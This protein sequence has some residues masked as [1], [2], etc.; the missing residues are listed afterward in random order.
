MLRK[1]ILSIAV[2]FAGTVSGIFAQNNDSGSFSI[3]DQRDRPSYNTWEVYT[4][5]RISRQIEDLSAFESGLIAVLTTG[6]FY[7]TENDLQ[8]DRLRLFGTAQGKHDIEATAMA[9]DVNGDKLWFSYANG[10]ISSF[11]LR[12]GQFRHF[13]DIARND[14]FL[15]NRINAMTY[16]DGKLYIGTD[17]GAV[18]FNTTQNFVIDS[19]TTL[20]TFA[21]MIPVRSVA[22]QNGRIY[23]GTDSGLAVGDETSSDLKI[24][25]NWVNYSQSNGFVSQAVSAIAA[26]GS[27]IYATSGNTNYVFDGNG[28]TT[29]SLF[30]GPVRRYR[31]ISA[32]KWS[33]VTASAAYE[34]DT[35]SNTVQVEM[36][37]E[38]GRTLNDFL[39]LGSLQ[40]APTQENG[41]AVRMG[42]V[43]EFDY[44]I[45]N[46][47][48]H[49]FFT[50]FHVAENG[51]LIGSTSP[52]PGRFNSGVF[53]T[54]FY[55][56]NEGNWQN[57]NSVTNDTMSLYGLS[58]YYTAAAAK[59]HYFFGSWGAGIAKY[60]VATGKVTRFNPGNAN[61]FG[62]SGTSNFYVAQGLAADRRNEDHVWAVSLG[63]PVNPLARYSIS[64][65][66]WESY[67]AIPQIG[68]ALRY[69][70]IYTD[71]YG[72]KWITLSNSALAGRGILVLRNPE[73]GSGEFFILNTNEDSGNL[74]N[75]QV[76][77]IVQD[78]RGEIWVGTDRG[79]SRF[80]FP[81]RIIGGSAMERRGQPLINEDTTAFDRV[82]LRDVRV[83]AL[84][85]D[86]NN[87]KWVGSDGDG[88]YLIEE[89]GRRVI[90]HFTRENSPLTSNTIESIAINTQTG[91]VFIATPN[92]LAKYSALEKEGLSRMNTLRIY[93]N[94]F[95]YQRD[96][97]SRVVIEDLLDNSTVHIMTVDGRLVRRFT[98]R[99]G[100]TDWDGLDSN[101]NRV[102]SG[103][104]LIVAT[105]N[106]NSEIGRG[107][108]VIV[109]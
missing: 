5:H 77:A 38:S 43:Q 108:L 85:V 15:S 76:N 95:S 3:F 17:F 40:I 42:S 26:S 11:D 12:T 6:G 67:N 22:V 102:S 87:Q 82:L 93:P 100:R 8:T 91:D 36:L 31:Q 30:N 50:K 81:D 88:I 71:T 78:R 79:I 98:T 7:I 69:Y 89:S 1:T 28:W 59:G 16:A 24:P 94:P 62:L 97:D 103:V 92:S 45:P 46:G 13:N 54:G 32:S 29:T 106:N 35:Q 47:P 55:I 34:L 25:G 105:G 101:G 52:A 61:I 10:M 65:G 64:T 4:S 9:Y 63:N 21:S 75:D 49:N 44:F 107:R 58:S 66:Q 90:R 2:I 84:A 104:Y 80:I 83:T 48:W 56:Y 33:V 14:R 51:D 86:A 18:V 19:Y 39:K 41:L 53:N 74:P 68:T 20:G 99:G 109:R 37:A 96:A 73:G 72:Q 23:A 57:F 60:N 70:D 27:R